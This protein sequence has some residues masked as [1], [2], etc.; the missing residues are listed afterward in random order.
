VSIILL[1]K[2]SFVNTFT[3]HFEGEWDNSCK[4]SGATLRLRT[5]LQEIVFK[6]HFLRFNF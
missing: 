2:N 3:Q 4:K 1:Q 5:F 6:V